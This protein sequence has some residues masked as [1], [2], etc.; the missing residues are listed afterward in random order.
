MFQ[1]VRLQR[2]LAGEHQLGHWDWTENAF[3]NTREFNGL[4][5]LMA[6]L[7]NWDLTD[8]NNAIYEV[9]DGDRKGERIYMVSDVGSTFGTGQL[10]WPM[11]HCRG[12]LNAYRHSKFITKVTGNTVDFY[13]PAGA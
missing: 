6:L 1:N 2:H 7:N 3:E 5:V 8:E 9:L 4:R 10:S 12:D 13:A 11:K